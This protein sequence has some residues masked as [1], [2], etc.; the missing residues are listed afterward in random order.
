ME[1]AF[2]HPNMK[3]EIY[4][5]WPEGIVDLGIKTKEFL[6][7]YCIFL[8]K[9]MYGNFDAEILWIRI[10]AKYLVNKFN[11][12]SIK[13]D[14]YIFV[15][16]YEKGKLE[17]VMSVHVEA[18]F[19]DGKPETLKTIREK[20]KENFNISEYGKFK[21]FLGVCYEWSHD[22]KCTS[23]KMTMEKDV[24]NLV[25]GYKKYTGNNLKVQKIPGV[26]GKTISKIN[27]EENDNIN[28]YRSFMEKLMWYTT[29]V[30]TDVANA[31]RELAVHMSHPGPEH[32]K[33]LGRLIGYLKGK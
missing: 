25:E 27:L 24:K 6:E 12:K 4:I 1:E 28:K 11:L 5:E 8:V 17:L 15:M 19:M 26:S 18:L 29:K 9:S 21:N 33:A 2:L 16:K 10:L 14:S 22:E 30:G 32:W 31:A 23:A 3:L 7:E 20:I 13:S